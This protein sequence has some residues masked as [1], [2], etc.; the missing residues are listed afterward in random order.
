MKRP[1]GNTIGMV[2]VALSLGSVLLFTAAQVSIT[3]LHLTSSLERRQL[4]RN[5]AETA[6]AETMQQIL[7]D[8]NFGAAGQSV[9]A[10]ASDYPPGSLGLVSFAAGAE[11]PRSTNN[12]R[13]NSAVAGALTEPVPAH[14]V[15]IIALGRVGSLEHKLQVLYH[16]PAF[17]KA[18]MASGRV[19]VTSSVRVSGMDPAVAYPSRS[20]SLPGENR[21][22][23][24]LGSNSTSRDPLRPAIY[25]GPGSYISGDVGACG[26]VKL[27]SS[28]SVGGEVRNGS[29]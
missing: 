21:R 3:H 16:R 1:Q 14:T 17:P 29:A 19:S 12:L 6:V 11:V 24:S 5:L 4:A 15:Q 8:E 10:D 23:A 26:L 13:G 9:R 25:L 18:L 22:P 28:A 27:D 7:L 2:T 20:G